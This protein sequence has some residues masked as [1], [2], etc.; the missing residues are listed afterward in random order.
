MDPGVE[1]GSFWKLTIPGAFATQ[2]AR[3]QW[4]RRGK[5]SLKQQSGDDISRWMIS[6]CVYF[7]GLVIHVV[8]DTPATGIPPHAGWRAS[9]AREIVHAA[10]QIVHHR[11]HS[12]GRSVVLVNYW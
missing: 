11:V 10:G 2:Q 7:V 1:L 12:Q 6:R 3:R 4:Q 9:F 8:F 5:G